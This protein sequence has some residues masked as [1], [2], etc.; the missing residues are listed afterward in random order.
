MTVREDIAAGRLT[1]VLEEF[2]VGASAIHVVY[3]H[4]RHL[5][6]KV[7]AFVDFLVAWFEKAQRSGRTC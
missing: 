3:P 1:A 7:R 5:S 6:G 2:E 4:R